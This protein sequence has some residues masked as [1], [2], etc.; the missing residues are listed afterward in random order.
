MSEKAV[1]AAYPLSP[2]Q[3]GILFHSLYA[4]EEGLYVVQ[5]SCDLR[6]ELDAGAFERAWQAVVDRHAVL[7]TG[8]TWKSGARPLQV[9]GRRVGVP[10]RIEDWRGIPSGEQEARFAAFLAEDRVRGFK[11]N[12]APLLRVALLRTG[13]REHRFVWTFH[14][15]LLDGWSYALVLAEVFQAYQA[16]RRSAE[17]KLGP[18]RPYRAFIDWL[19]ARDRPAEEAFWRDRLRGIDEAERTVSGGGGPAFLARETELTSEATADLERAARRHRTTM[20]TLVQGALAL[21]LGRSTERG[22]VVL[23]SVVSGRPPELPGVEGIVGMFINTLPVR[24][25]VS[26]EDRVGA[27]LEALQRQQAELRLHENGGLVDLQAWSGLPAGEPLFEAVVIFE[28]YPVSSALDPAA[29]GLE[30]GA[31]RSEIRSNYPL[32]LAVTPGERLKLRVSGSGGRFD[33]PAL[34][35]MLGHLG[36][37]L[38][39]LA[40]DPEAPLA[41]LSIL[42]EAERHQL[43]REWSDTEEMEER[44]EAGTVV[45]RF[46]AQ[47]ERTPDAEAVAPLTYGEL[48]RRSGELAC[49]LSGLGVGPEVRVGLYLERTPELAVALLGIWR[50]GGAYVPLD[51]SYPDARLALLLED[52]GAAVVVTEERWRDRLTGVRRVCMEHLGEEQGPERRPS[53]QDLAYLIYTSGTTGRPKAVMVEHGSLANL[54]DG[55][56]AVGRMPCLAA[57]TFDIFLFELL[58]PLLSG[59]ASVIYGHRPTL[60]VEAV[61]ADLAE[62]TRLHAVPAVMRQIVERAG[63]APHLEELYV[64]GDLVPTDLLTAMRERFPAARVRVLYGPTE[65]TILAT[66]STDGAGAV[67][68]RPLKNVRLRLTDPSGSPVPIGMAGEIRIGGPGVSRGYLGQEELT[69]ERFVESDGERW[70]RTG[71]LGRWLADGRVEFLGRSDDQ[72][73]VRGFRIELGEVESAM[74]R[75]PGVRAAAAAVRSGRLVG[76]YVGEAG[77]LR[78]FLESELPAPLVPS[79]LVELESLPLT[80][81]GKVDRRSLP[82]P[83]RTAAEPV[84]PRTPVEEVL[85]G[86]WAGLLGQERVGV[87]DS[88]FE[89]G[90]HS[91]LATQLASRIREVFEVELP[92]ARLFE[93]PTVAGLAAAVTA[94]KDVPAAPPLEPV[95][96]DGDLPLSFAQERIW[97]FEQLEPGTPTYNL[98]LALRLEGE[99]DAAALAGIFGAIVERHEAL[100][101]VFVSADGEPRQRVEPPALWP[102]PVVSGSLESLA[103]DEALRPF[104]LGRGPLL[105]T[106]LVRLG[107]REH[108]LL[109][110]LH[111]IAA[112]AW[113]MGVLVEEVQ[114]LWAGEALRPLPVQYGDY[115]VWQRR[116]LQG[117]ALERLA[118]YWREH[119]AGAPT[120]LELPTDRPRPAVQSFRGAACTLELD[121]RLSE[122][123]RA[124]AR[125]RSATLFMVLLAGF[126][127]LLG[128]LSDREDVVVGTPIAGRSRR[129]LEGLIGFFVNTLALRGDLSGDPTFGE[130]VGRARRAAL[131]GYEHQ[132]LPFEKLVEELQP[133]RS[134][135]HAPLFQAM[136]VLQN[137][138]LGLVEVPGVSL[139]VER[140]GA[141]AAEHDWTLEAWDVDGRIR[142]SLQY[143]T[144]LFDEATIRRALGHLET[145][146]EAAVE[147]PRRKVWD[148]PLLRPVERQQIVSEWGEGGAA[149]S[150]EVPVHERIAALAAERP[151]APAVVFA[152]GALSFEE[153]AARSRRLAL[154]LRGLGVGPESVVALCVERSP[155][156][157]VGILGA[158]AASGAYLPL[159]PSYPKD[160]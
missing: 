47:A 10:V 127:T 24:V 156:M 153:L 117:E 44:A 125:G 6:G 25:P 97:F 84:A 95:E 72:V 38:A 151:G 53:P 5:L 2:V 27:W 61:A 14:H 12:R 92:L 1:E 108:V 51:P 98:P 140:R 132:D 129:E 112:D 115:A 149:G 150:G 133:E 76:W 39:G 104:D 157:A 103:E 113:S 141:V 160:R 80:P 7:R 26:G 91:L 120:L 100:R 22:E 123:L 36:R 37:L 93:A 131:G 110:T 49:H 20:S 65:A 155:E 121:G 99:V 73:K 119:L 124:L 42:S 143:R 75:H 69:R 19:Q 18:V 142:T 60:D 116:W 16:L 3:E 40:A 52:S 111:H 34:D 28:N 70:Y 15:L 147:E 159:D 94:Q 17:P 86:I 45:D 33:A 30:V 96:R 90:G 148:L 139:A 134:L 4:P 77:D 68:G 87:H 43:L 13:E 154:E 32:N 101:T 145:L 62:M 23:G 81:H 46:L 79:V 56:E 126:E 67:I 128:R 41:S 58:S 146:L 107:E 105:R 74:A 63:E 82:D 11:L 35:R 59:G 158:L 66:S 8:F 88:F 106:T 57:H 118:A 114:R 138:P 152:D 54:L 29:L 136:L 71:D 102:L 137:A 48:A 78:S 21:W 64:G 109:L 9:V 85:A 130:L 122:G 31:L 83:E 55:R 50:A 135:G 89:L 144:D